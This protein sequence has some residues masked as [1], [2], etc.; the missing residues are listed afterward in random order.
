MHLKI[1]EVVLLGEEEST[2]RNGRGNNDRAGFD[3]FATSGAFI[4]AWIRV[5]IYLQIPPRVFCSKPQESCGGFANQ[6]LE[7]FSRHF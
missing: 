2:K 1:H 5:Y 4:L 7:A 3:A 6:C